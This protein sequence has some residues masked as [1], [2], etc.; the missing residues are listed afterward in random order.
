MIRQFMFALTVLLITTS[1]H[2]HSKLTASVPADGTVVEAPS[3]ISL[4]YN[5]PIRLV[6]VELTGPN[7]EEV[8]LELDTDAGFAMDHLAALSGDTAGVYT[9]EWKGFSKDGHLLKGSFSFEVE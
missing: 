2:A 3:Q 4:S 5:K 1:A 8:A 6:S 9:V 7:G